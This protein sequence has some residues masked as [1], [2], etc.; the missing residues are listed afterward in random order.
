MLGFFCKKNCKIPHPR[1]PTAKKISV[2]V[3]WLG[4]EWST[5]ATQV[6]LVPGMG[7]GAARTAHAVGRDLP[8]RAR[9]V[10]R[11]GPGPGL[12]SGHPG[13]VRAN[14]DWVPAGWRPGPSRF[15]PLVVNQT[16]LS[17]EV[18]IS[19]WCFLCCSTFFPFVFYFFLR[20][21]SLIILLNSSYSSLA[22]VS[23]DWRGNNLLKTILLISPSTHWTKLSIAILPH[24]FN[25][26]RILFML[27]F[28][29][30]IL[31]LFPTA[32]IFFKV[33]NI[34]IQFIDFRLLHYF[35]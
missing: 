11:G 30:F 35:L 4:L 5:G 21:S 32:V 23:L 14:P 24:T 7:P 9:P 17:L 26:K 13:R 3:G 22:C 27:F 2:G 28:N 20:A 34:P 33:S 16:S 19:I 10:E 25:S 31:C 8:T 6:Q 15:T 12:G 1:T 18:Q 29:I